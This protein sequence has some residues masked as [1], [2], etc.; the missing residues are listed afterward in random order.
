MCSAWAPLWD[1]VKDGVNC[2]V[3]KQPQFKRYSSW[4]LSNN[5]T[6]YYCQSCNRIGALGPYKD[7]ATIFYCHECQHTGCVLGCEHGFNEAHTYCEHDGVKYYGK[8]D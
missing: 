7:K 5:G 4:V 1:I 2:P 8:H 3:C 6:L